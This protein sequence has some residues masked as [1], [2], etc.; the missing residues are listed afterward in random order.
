LPN[1]SQVLRELEREHKRDEAN[2]RRRRINPTDK[3]RRRYVKKLADYTGRNVICYYSGWLM[4]PNNPTET[5]VTDADK[6]GF[7]SVIHGMDRGKGLDLMLHTPG[8]N[9]AA[10]ESLVDYLRQ[11]FGTNI[12]AIIPQL[13]M[14][15]GTMMACASK[16]IVMGKQSNLGPTDPQVRGIPASEVLKEFAQAVEEIR[17]DPVAQ[18]VWRPIIEKYHPTFLRDCQRA[19][20]WSNEITREWLK[21]GML[22]DCPDADERSQAIAVQLSDT[23][24]TYSHARHIHIDQLEAMGL[25]IERLEEDDELQDLVL[26]VHHAYMHT[27]ASTNTY[28]IIEDHRSGMLV[29]GGPQPAQQ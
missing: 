15:A 26:T 19:V 2:Q 9:I 13:A 8:G 25:N 29:V 22:A 27:F 21:D 6:N 5:S 16:S 1:W 14:S 11:M 7:M 3:V 17:K 20:T 4:R 23:D 24:S 18:T 10:T 28:K 12:R